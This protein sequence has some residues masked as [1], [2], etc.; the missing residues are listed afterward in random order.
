M[1]IVLVVLGIV[2]LVLGL[3]GIVAPGLPDAPLVFAGMLFLG[4]GFGFDR[5]S[6]LT[7][8][9]LGVLAALMWGAEFA[10][11]ALGAKLAKASRL[12]SI[13][14]VI[15]AFLGFFAGSLPG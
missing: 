3:L 4:G 11:T 14:A 8:I 12:A 7:W 9:L 6:I 10:S 13:F 15:G 1:E 5:L 2:L